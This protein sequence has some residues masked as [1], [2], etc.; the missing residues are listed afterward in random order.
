MSEPTTPTA[1]IVARADKMF[2]LRRYLIVLLIVGVGGWF[3]YDGFYNWPKEKRDAEAAIAAQEQPREKP[4]SDTDIFAN[5]VLGVVLPPVGLLV[6]AWFMYTSRGEY[7]LSGQTLSV[8]GHPA[9]PLSAITLIDKSKWDRKG[10]VRI[11][12]ETTPGQPGSLRLDDFV[13]ER[14]PTDQI[15]QRLEASL[16]AENQQDDG[17]KS[18]P[19]S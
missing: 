11:E 1:D 16:T 7:R 14:V 18:N 8:P 15:L 2:R 6:L 4:H 17:A 3:C 10:I 9:I 13:Y 12:Y 19:G 5:Q